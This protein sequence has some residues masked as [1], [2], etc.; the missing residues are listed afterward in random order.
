M[1]NGR[2]CQHNGM[3]GTH[4]AQLTLHRHFAQWEILRAAAALTAGPEA[5]ND[6][7][8][9]IR[10]AILHLLPAL[11]RALDHLLNSV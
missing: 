3:Q 6:S 8:D 4:T 1:L 9:V 5:H 2:H 7:S 10:A 11:R